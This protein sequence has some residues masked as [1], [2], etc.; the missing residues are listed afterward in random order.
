MA[1]GATASSPPGNHEV[2]VQDWRAD[3]DQWWAGVLRVPVAA[4][5]AGGVFALGHVDH[6]G[7]VA[8]EGAAAPIVYGPA[9]VLPALH[10]AARASRGGLAEGQHLAAALAPRAGRVHG[11]AWY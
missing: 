10:A 8:V 3:V 5:R 2:T 7:A 9:Q 11:P 1:S 6:A 4:V